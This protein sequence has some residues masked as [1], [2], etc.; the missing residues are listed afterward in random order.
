MIKNLTRALLIITV[1]LVGPVGVIYGIFEIGDG[2]FSGRSNVKSIDGYY[3]IDYITISATC[4][5]LFILAFALL[6]WIIRGRKVQLSRIINFTTISHLFFIPSFLVSLL[7]T[8]IPVEGNIKGFIIFPAFILASLAGIVGFLIFFIIKLIKAKKE[9]NNG[10]KIKLLAP[11]GIAIVVLLILQV[12][13]NTKGTTDIDIISFE[14][15]N[16]TWGIQ[17]KKSS[18]LGMVNQRERNAPYI[19]FINHKNENDATRLT[20]RKSFHSLYTEMQHVI[21][22]QT[23]IIR[24]KSYNR[25]V[26]NYYGNHIEIFS[27]QKNEKIYRVKSNRNPYSVYI[28]TTQTSHEIAN[29]IAEDLKNKHFVTNILDKVH[30]DLI[31]ESVSIGEAPSEN[32]IIFSGPNNK[33]ITVDTYGLVKMFE[34]TGKYDPVIDLGEIHEGIYYSYPGALNLESYVNNT[35]KPF[36]YKNYKNSKNETLDTLYPHV[37]GTECA[38]N[39]N[40]AL[41]NCKNTQYLYLVDSTKNKE[42]PESINKLENLFALN[43][44]GINIGTIPNSICE[45]KKLNTIS[46]NGSKSV[47]LPKCIEEIS[48]LYFIEITNSNLTKIPTA[49]TKMNNLMGL[50]FRGNNITK[51]PKEFASFRELRNITVDFNE[52]LEIPEELLKIEEFYMEFI[53]YN[54]SQTIKAEAFLKKINKFTRQDTGLNMYAWNIIKSY[55]E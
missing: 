42:I 51:I 15:E 18:K 17:Q 28:N 46:I 55:E 44:T 33:K 50:D 41:K 39:V 22:V 37:N 25:A 2:A 3:L 13:I 47:E 27:S 45:L 16:F 1:A 36:L 34:G 32:E 52:K 12:G 53:T 43:I 24:L 9:N 7:L 49:F 6:G 10:S 54:E 21:P 35:I 4:N 40:Y 8:I 20:I 19:I 31:I 29:I 38:S 14:H 11:Y 23:E 30:N 48:T 5:L 26:G